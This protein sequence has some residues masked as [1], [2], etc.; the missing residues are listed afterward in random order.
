MI[1]TI[2]EARRIVGVHNRIHGGSSRARKDAGKLG[3]SR[4]WE[5]I[6][7]QSMRDIAAMERAETRKELADIEKL[8]NPQ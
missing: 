7:E 6:R 3:V 5:A 1:Y 4:T 2:E 8:L